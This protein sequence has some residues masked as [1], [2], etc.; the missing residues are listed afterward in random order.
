MFLL[1]LTSLAALAAVFYKTFIGPNDSS[2]I[3][4]PKSRITIILASG[5][6]APKWDDLLRCFPE[7]EFNLICQEPPENSVFE[8]QTQDRELLGR[9]KWKKSN[10]VLQRDTEFMEKLRSLPG[11]DPKQCFLWTEDTSLYFGHLNIPGTLI[12][13]FTENDAYANRLL[14]RAS[15]DTNEGRYISSVT[16]GPFFEEGEVCFLEAE[17]RGELV[18]P[19]GK[20]KIDNQLRLYHR[21]RNIAR[22][23]EHR[24][25]DH[26]RYIVFR[27]TA[28][29][30]GLVF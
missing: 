12:K 23:P 6:T 9:R 27:M 16:F 7:R 29:K 30:M 26:P 2:G 21:K 14:E 4:A 15:P 1:I 17:V 22:S 10:K 13:F 24:P 28:T 25:E 18:Q 20:G 3:A 19:D 8:T 11:F 5:S